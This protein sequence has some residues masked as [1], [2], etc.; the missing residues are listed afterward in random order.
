M[1]VGAGPNTKAGV[2]ASKLMQRPLKVDRGL[3]ISHIGN[4]PLTRAVADP[5]HGLLRVER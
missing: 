4:S 1:T 3:S 2:G 5:N